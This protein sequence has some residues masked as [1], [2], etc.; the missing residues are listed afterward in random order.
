[1]KRRKFLKTVGLGVAATAVPTALIASQTRTDWDHVVEAGRVMEA[2]DFARKISRIFLE[3]FEAARAL[4][5]GVV[6]GSGRHV[7]PEDRVTFKRPT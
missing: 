5:P 7:F 4:H 6:H 3:K 1:M 2:D